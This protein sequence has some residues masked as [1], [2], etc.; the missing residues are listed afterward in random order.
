MVPIVCIWFHVENKVIL[1]DEIVLHSAQRLACVYNT[2]KQ[3]LKYIWNYNNISK[4]YKSFVFYKY[5]L[6]YRP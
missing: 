2:L 1:L 3:D 5:K 6:N 4:I